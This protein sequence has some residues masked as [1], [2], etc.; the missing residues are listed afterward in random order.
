MNADDVIKKFYV[1]LL[2]CLPMDNVMFRANLTAADLLPR[3]LKD[4]VLSKTTRAEKAEYF[5]DNVINNT[6]SLSRLLAVMKKSEHNRLKELA[7]NI[8]SCVETG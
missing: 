7:T 5:L 8:E 4:T 3:D 2:A 6:E 1:E